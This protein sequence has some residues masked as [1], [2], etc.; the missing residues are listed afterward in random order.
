MTLERGGA[1]EGEGEGAP[2]VRALGLHAS[3]SAVSPLPAAVAPTVQIQMDRSEVRRAR[4]HHPCQVE[5]HHARGL[6]LHSEDGDL[7]GRS[8]ERTSLI[9]LQTRYD[10][11]SL[12]GLAVTILYM[13]IT[14]FILVYF[15][16]L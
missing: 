3:A 2:V 5:R 6:D 13:M 4:R 11:M 15:F 10:L 1:E 12:L 9:S 8:G 16:F 7:R 14:R